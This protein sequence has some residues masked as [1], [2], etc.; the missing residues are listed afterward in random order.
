MIRVCTRVVMMGVWSRLVPVDGGW[1]E[2]LFFFGKYV[3]LHFFRE[4]SGGLFDD[5]FFKVSRIV[6]KV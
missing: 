5:I 3:F 6:K 4:K 2:I 1:R